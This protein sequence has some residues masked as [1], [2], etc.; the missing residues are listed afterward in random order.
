M[1]TCLRLLRIS[2]LVVLVACHNGPV[3]I[4]E[5]TR[6][7]NGTGGRQRVSLPD[8]SHV[9]LASGTT[10]VLSK[11]F[12]TGAR[13]V[14]LDGEGFFEIASVSAGKPFVLHTANLL[15]EVLGTRFHIDAYRKNAGEQVDL[16]EGRLRV[17]KSYHSDTDNN[18][19]V[20]EAGEMVMINRDI[21]L[22]EKEKLSPTEL[23]KLKGSW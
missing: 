13:E 14:E 4:G 17:Q 16:L 6:Y 21:D 3:L 9:V 7:V 12:A 19:E 15:I 11:G 1:R 5:G 10:I 2:L 23:D 18:P 8:G 20:L 22:M